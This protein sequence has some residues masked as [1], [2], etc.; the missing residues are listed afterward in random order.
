MVLVIATRCNCAIVG[1]TPFAYARPQSSVL[2]K[3]KT[4]QTE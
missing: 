1:E 4:T 2:S 3:K